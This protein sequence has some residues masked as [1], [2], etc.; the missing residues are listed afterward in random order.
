MSITIKDVAK[1]A[2]VSIATASVAINNKSGVSDKSRIKVLEAVEKLGYK[3]N[4]YAR[5]LITKR[6]KTVGLIVSDILNPFFGLII[7]YIQDDIEK[8]GYTLLLRVSNEQIAVEKRIVDYFIEM[9]IEGLIIVPSLEMQPDLSH[10]YNLKKLEIPFVFITTYYKQ[11]EADCIMCD[12]GEG[13]YQLT[14][15]LLESG[16]E[17]IYFLYGHNT[18]EL[19]RLR[20]TGFIKAYKE[21]G[22]NYRDSQIVECYPDYSSGY[23]VTQKIIA[24]EKPDAIITV[25]DMVALGTMKCLKDNNIK[26]PD[27]M[28]VAGYDDLLYASILDTPLT[29]VRQ[30][31]EDICKE[32]VRTLLN[33][34]NGS[35]YPKKKVL[36]KPTLIVR[37]STLGKNP[38]KMI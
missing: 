3:P 8:L 2:G 29:T 4:H 21:Y 27:E 10:L 5:R 7:K 38:K 28:S 1:L 13:S 22:L 33:R 32:S 19:S 15:Y 26:V 16:K 23:S 37:D 30:P 25:N 20:L 24:Q 17:N 6:S 31:I 9:D 11:I 35:T 14:K 34:I 12:L 18:L 36:L